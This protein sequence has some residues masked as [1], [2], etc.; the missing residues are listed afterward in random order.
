LPAIHLDARAGNHVVAAAAGQLAVVGHGRHVEQHAVL[1]LVG[2]AFLDQRLD[3]LD[4]AADMLG[5]VRPECR[6]DHA[7]RAHLLTVNPL[8]KRGDLGD[9]LPGLGGDGDDLV[10]HVRDVGGIDNMVRPV[11]FTQ[12]AKQHVECDGRPRIADMGVRI[13]R[14]SADIH[15]HPLGVLRGKGLLFPGQRVVEAEVHEGGLFD[16]L[17][18]FNKVLPCVRLAFSQE[19]PMCHAH[20]ARSIWPG[21]A[22]ILRAS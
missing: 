2:V 8:V 7:K 19:A 18:I 16:P 20:P 1:A 5:C 22:M 6:L 3:D 4:H 15:C 10:V 13:D 17:G 14:R 12:Q 11:A 21:G 9:R